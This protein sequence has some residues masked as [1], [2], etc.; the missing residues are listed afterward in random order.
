M[1]NEV[2]R[3]MPA[4]LR[5][6]AATAGVAGMLVAAA[7]SMPSAAARPAPMQHVAQVAQ[8]AQA[9][10]SQVPESKPSLWQISQSQAPSQAH[11][12]SPSPKRSRFLPSTMFVQAGVAEEAQMAI[13]GATWVW[14]WY[15]D[16]SIGRLG[17]YW[18]V[19]I[20]RWNSDV[21]DNG[22]SAWVTQFGVTPVLR[23]YPHSWGGRWF[24][25]GGIGA[26]VLQPIYRSA[27]KRFSTA[28]NFGDHLAIGRRFGIDGRHELALRFQ[29]FSNA[30]IKE[31]NPGENFLQLRYS[32][33]F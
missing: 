20:G 17:G 6:R 28:F 31:P 22:G 18:E 10:Q 2:R 27:G 13:V 7:V 1:R 30:G 11:P 24:V 4:R 8:V 29:H 14:D 26:N 3:A 25:E 19:S 33:E 32:W 21:E 9:A 12:Q 16:F 15:R 23:L 5:L